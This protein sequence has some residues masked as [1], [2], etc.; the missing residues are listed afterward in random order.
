VS[1]K[2]GPRPKAFKPINMAISVI[3]G[4][5]YPQTFYSIRV[6]FNSGLLSGN[7]NLLFVAVVLAGLNPIKLF[8]CC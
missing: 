6:G 2:V 8:F 3:L 7:I 5:F 4:Q 1:Q